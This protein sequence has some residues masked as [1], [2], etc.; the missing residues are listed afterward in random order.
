MEAVIK[1]AYTEYINWEKQ[2]NL[3]DLIKDLDYFGIELLKEEA[4]IFLVRTLSPTNVVDVYH[5][6]EIYCDKSLKERSQKA[7]T[8]NFETVSKS[9]EFL[10]LDVDSFKNILSSVPVLFCSE[11]IFEG[12]LSW[13]AKDIDTRKSYLMEL[14]GLIQFGG[15][16]SDMVIT[17]MTESNILTE[18]VQHK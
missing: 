11:K 7:I 6:S 9:D 1:F 3:P 4:I 16:D 5:L 13:I 10:K 14:L 17:V 18:S 15:V 8:A 12:V 2:K